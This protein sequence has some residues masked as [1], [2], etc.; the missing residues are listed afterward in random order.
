MQGARLPETPAVEAAR[1]QVE[2]AARDLFAAHGNLSQAVRQARKEC[3]HEHRPKTLAD[4]NKRCWPKRFY[5]G[6]ECMK[7]GDFVPRTKG[8]WYMICEP[9]GGKMHDD[10]M[11]PG[12]GGRTWVHVC[13]NCGHTAHSS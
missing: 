2:E 3:P 9:C 12:Q 10:G 11:I 7:C 4:P 8:P 1:T 6:K 13:E 5:L